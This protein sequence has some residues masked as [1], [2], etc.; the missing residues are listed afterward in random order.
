MLLQCHERN[1]V[2]ATRVLTSTFEGVSFLFITSALHACVRTLNRAMGN[3]CKAHVEKFWA[4]L[5]IFLVTSLN[6]RTTVTMIHPC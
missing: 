2:L 6:I 5:Y 1:A 3:H 4:V